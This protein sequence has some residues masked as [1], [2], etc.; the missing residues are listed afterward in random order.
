MTLARPEFLDTREGW[1]GRLSSYTSL[2]LGRS[3]RGSARA[4]VRRLGAP[5]RADAVVRIAEGNPLFIEQLA[6]TMEETE[7]AL[8][9]SGPTKSVSRSVASEHGAHPGQ[10]TPV[11]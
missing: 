1:G 11:R 5:D 4:R 9:T 3:T 8:P 7:G 2:T 6:A 10:P